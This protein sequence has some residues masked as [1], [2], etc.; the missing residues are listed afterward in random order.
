MKSEPRILVLPGYVKSRYDGEIHHI[1][2]NQLV[3]LYHLDIG[4]IIVINDLSYDFHKKEIES[5]EALLATPLYSGE[6]EVKSKE[7]KLEL[8]KRRALWEDWKKENVT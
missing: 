3:H 2:A 4:E 8:A 5:E 1:N 7:L 6:Y